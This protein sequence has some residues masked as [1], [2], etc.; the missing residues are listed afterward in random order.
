MFLFA[1]LGLRNLTATASEIKELKL[2]EL[3]PT[4]NQRSVQGND[5]SDD[6]FVNP[7]T[8]LLR[9][10]S[11]HANVP[12]SNISLAEVQRKICMFETRQNNLTAEV[13]SLKTTMTEMRSYFESVFSNLQETIMKE[14]CILFF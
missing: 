6:D 10:S 11:S 5:N 12:E 3:F 7:P 13:D 1:Q 8:P 14:V 2:E 4:S 9:L